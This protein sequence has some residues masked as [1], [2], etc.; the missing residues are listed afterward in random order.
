MQLRKNNRTGRRVL[1]DPKPPPPRSYLDNNNVKAAIQLIKRVPESDE[2][3]YRRP[4]GGILRFMFPESEGYEVVP[5]AK[6]NNTLSDFCTY[7]VHR[8]PAGSLYQYEFL[9]TEV[10]PVGESWRTTEVQHREQCAGTGNESKK[11]YGSIQIGLEFQFYKFEGEELEKMG[12][13]M[14]MERDHEQIIAWGEHLKANPLP[15][16]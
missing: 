6:G 13:K 2:H 14:H 5:E 15:V 10:K 11:C 12:G 1:F 7:N 3:I 16:V 9:H 4:T 8:R